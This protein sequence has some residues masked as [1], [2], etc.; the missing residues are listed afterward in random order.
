MATEYNDGPQLK[1]IS[2]T[3]QETA[4]IIGLLAAQLG[5]VTLRGNQG[6]ACP[7]VN[8]LDHGNVKYRITFIVG[9]DPQ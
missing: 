9:S 1:I 5:D 8:V 4:N 6:G 2:L 3:R 7:D